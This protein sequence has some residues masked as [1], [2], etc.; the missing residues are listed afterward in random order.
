MIP[1]QD[2]S[3]T[4]GGVSDT[5]DNG[6]AEDMPAGKVQAP[7]PDLYAQALA[8][9]RQSQVLA[10][11][12][13]QSQ[14]RAMENWQ[15]IQASW[16]RA[17]EIRMLRRASRRDPDLLRHSAYARMQ[18]KLASLPV[19]EQAKGIIMAQCGWP[20][21]QAFDALR[22]ASQREN[23]KLR[24]VAARV[25]AAAVSSAPAPAQPG[26]APVTGRSS[27][28]SSSA[29]VLSSSKERRRASA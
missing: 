4:A 17:H 23:V 12:L 8:A 19:I 3:Q 7:L 14:R 29:A 2:P 28:K 10:E 22:R 21:D 11:Q 5:T 18:A 16:E 15:L 20:E 25:V 26:R 27:G 24:E 6:Y 9:R 1:P 13:R